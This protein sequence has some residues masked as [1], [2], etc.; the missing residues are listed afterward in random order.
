MK[1]STEGAVLVDEHGR[2]RVLHGINLVQKE[3]PFQAAW[4]AEDLAQLVDM[5]L[6]AVRLGVM[7]AAVEPEPGL[8]DEEHLAHL[9]EQLDMLHRAGLAVVLDAHQDLFSQS[10]GDGAPAWATL[11]THAYEPAG[12]WSEAYLSSSAVQESL[13]AFWADAPGP[14]GVGIRS[15]FVAMWAHVARRLVGHPAVI[16]VDVLNEPAPGALAGQAFEALL[17]SLAA[18]TGQEPG[19]VAEE[20]ADPGRRLSQ[21]ARLEDPALHRAVTDDVA[22]LLAPFES[23][24]VQDL[25]VQAAA[26]IRE[27]RPGMLILREHGY[28]SN[29]GVPAAI[30]P[31]EGP[32]AYSPHGYDLVVDTEAMVLASDQRISTI[33]A[34]AAETA[35]RLGA[36]VVVGEWGAFGDLVGIGAHAETQLEMFDERSWSWFYWTWESSF[37]HSEAAGHLRRPHPVAVAGRELRAGHSAGGSWKAAWTGRA[38]AAPTEFWVPPERDV[39]LIIDGARASILREGARVLIDPLEGEHRLRVL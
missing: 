6:D 13:D 26:A 28:F 10:F 16:A 19:V 2:Q 36:P 39:E 3:A 24:P 38:C 29:L 14:G 17:G 22:G 37:P 32:W 15:R 20:L 12:L 11:T 4:D 21:L 5:G 30:A 27:V 9:E 23:G 35:Q 8:Y 25:F 7:W 1:L 31:L 18:R 34:R 33:F